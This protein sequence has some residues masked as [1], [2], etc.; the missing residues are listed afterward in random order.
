MGKE[1]RQSRIGCAAVTLLYAAALILLMAALCGCTTTKYI[2]VETVRTEYKDRVETAYTTDSV[3][4][5]RFVYVNGDTIVDWREKVKW[6]DRYVHDSVF[7]EIRDTIREPYP[8]EKELTTWQKAKMDFG[9]MAFGVSGAAL[10]FVLS[11]VI[12]KISK[13]A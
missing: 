8:V 10:I 12:R 9:G 5:T 3:T 11:V 7:V 13:R 6:R 4:D 2:P 1:R